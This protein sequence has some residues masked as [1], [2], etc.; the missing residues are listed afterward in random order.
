MRVGGQAT[1]YELALRLEAHGVVGPTTSAGALPPFEWQPGS[2]PTTSHQGQPH[3]FDFDFEHL[4]P[5]PNHG[6]FFREEL[7][8]PAAE[9][10]VE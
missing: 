4:F 8:S 10:L 9:R 3:K 1:N 6:S 5:Y 7:S 2:F